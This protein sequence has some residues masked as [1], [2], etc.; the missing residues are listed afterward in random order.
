MLTL[1]RIRDDYQ[2]V[3]DGLAKRGLDKAADLQAVLALDDKRKLLQ[4][5]MDELAAE[6]N[7]LSD[8]IGSLFR[9]GRRE[10]ADTMKQ[11]VAALKTK[12]TDLQTPH[13]E[14][15]KEID[16]LLVTIPNVPYS[17]VVAGKS[18]A[19]NV[20]VKQGGSDAMPNGGLPHWELAKKFDIIDFELGNQITGSGFP[21]FKGRGARLERALI[22]FFLDRATENGYLEIIPPLMVNY[23]TAYSTGQLPD[24]EGQMY[25][26]PEDGFFMI[27]TAEVPITNIYRNHIF[28]QSD[29]PVKMAGYTPCFRRE[30]GSYGKDV[31]G[32]NRV[33]QFDKV[34]IVQFSDPAHSYAALEDMVAHVEELIQILGLPYRIVRLCGGDMGFTSAM[35]YD[36]E[37]YSPAQDK[38][39]EVSSV[40]NFE[41]FQANRLNARM[42]DEQNKK[43]LVHTLNGSALAL[44]RI[45]AALLEY[46]QDDTGIEIP[47][48]LHGYTGFTRIG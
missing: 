1:Q 36:F 40:S 18:A 3:V 30:A 26:I 42:R 2:N 12:V 28:Q 48:I 35:T 33:H 20:I 19:D 38:W 22:S 47:S 27:P 15:V 14:V 10:E 11:L 21:V 41:T 34:E 29:L 37:V 8:S 39:L 43:Q 4:K 31:R 24:K 23:Q 32:L 16:A 45:V 7:N 6:L 46:Y 44:P 13:D 25:T 17:L 9:E 5:Q